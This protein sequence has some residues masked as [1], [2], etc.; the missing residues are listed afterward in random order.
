[1]SG[2]DIDEEADSFKAGKLGKL[3]DEVERYLKWRSRDLKKN[4]TVVDVWSELLPATLRERCE[5]ESLSRGVLTVGV[6]PGVYMHELRLI[7]DELVEQLRQRNP[8]AG[9]K[10]IKVV[11]R[12]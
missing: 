3:G 1:M 5:I 12:V 11:A 8:R 9:V 6:E 4:A 10:R 7:S 2:A